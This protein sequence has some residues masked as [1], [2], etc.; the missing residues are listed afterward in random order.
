MEFCNGHSHS[1][2]LLEVTKILDEGSACK[3]FEA[4]CEAQGGMR[5]LQFASFKY[6]VTAKNKGIVKRI[7]NHLIGRIAKLAGAPDSPTAGVDLHTPLKTH[8]EKGQPLFTIY[9]TSAGELDH[10]LY[11]YGAHEQVIEIDEA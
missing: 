3:K 9:A 5:E 8:I 10:A 4:I 11:Y 1:A 2:A 7:D 6:V